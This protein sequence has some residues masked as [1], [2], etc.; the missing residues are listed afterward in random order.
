MKAATKKI[1]DT[2]WESYPSLKLCKP[3]IIAAWGYLFNCYKK[4][5]KVM[6]C[7]NGGSAADAE[8]IVGEL[9]NKFMR[10]RPIPDEHAQRLAAVA[11]PE[12]KAISVKLMCALP[13]ISLVSQSALISA[14][15]NDIAADM[16]YAQQVY[17][18]GQKNDV[19][20]AIST[21]GNSSNVLNAIRVAKALDV[22][23]VGLTGE[24]GAAMS[25]LCDATIHVPAVVTP[26]VQELHQPIYHVL[27]EMLE[28]EFFGQ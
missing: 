18:Y 16:V 1:L 25:G 3:D 12:G 9:M 20:I 13:A 15:A 8:H 21:S 7:G 2:L 10:K 26:H 14:V 5:G 11:G 17:G 6:A 23:T 28:T 27:C 19:L 24:G 22:K 4:R